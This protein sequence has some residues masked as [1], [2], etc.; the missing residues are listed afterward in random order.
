MRLQVE[1]LEKEKKGLNERLRFI[2]K[3]LDH[4]ERAFRKEERPLLALDYERQQAEDR[5]VFEEAQKRAIEEARE[6][7]KL[8]LE[9][10]KRMSRM[11]GDYKARKDFYIGRRGA[12][13]AKKKADAEAK[14]EKEMKERYNAVMKE[15]EERRREIEEEERIR[16]EKE[17]EELRLEEGI[18]VTFIVACRHV[19]DFYIFVFRATR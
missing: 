12:E 8:N 18:F 16:R 1:Q 11:L 17:E 15:R 19:S 9:A 2:A 4:T 6:A 13:Y 5:A 10:K 3:R 7:H 14:I